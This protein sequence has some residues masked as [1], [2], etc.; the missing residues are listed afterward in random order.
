MHKNIRDLRKDDVLIRNDGERCKIL[1]VWGLDQYR[2]LRMIIF[3]G[4]AIGNGRLNVAPLVVGMFRCKY[5]LVEVE[6]DA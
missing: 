4:F 2:V 3:E 5:G 1:S 6:E